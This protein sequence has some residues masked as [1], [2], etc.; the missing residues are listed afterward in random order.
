[1][2]KVMQHIKHQSSWPFGFLVEDFKTM[3]WRGAYF[4]TTLVELHARFPMQPSFDKYGH[5]V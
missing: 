1:M 3:V 5:L 2:T 4:L